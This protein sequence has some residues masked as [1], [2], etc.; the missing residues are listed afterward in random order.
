MSDTNALPGLEALLEPQNARPGDVD[1]S[2]GKVYTA[3]KLFRQH[4]NVFKA[5]ARLLFRESLS[6]RSVAATLML[7]V[8]T[9]RAIRDM[10]VQGRVGSEA[11]AA[12][13]FIKSRA[14]SAKKILQL[15]ALEEIHDRI[16]NDSLNQIDINTLLSVVKAV[17][18]AEPAQ[19]NEKKSGEEF[20]E[21][22]AFDDV[23][24]GLSGEEFPRAA[25]SAAGGADDASRMPGADDP[26]GPE[27]STRSSK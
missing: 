16:E 11:A 20:I 10:V 2:D 27:C 15:R 18:T 23:L 25:D 5:A 14:V 19:P 21:G 4:P 8:N 3:E 13:F 1:M 22:E 6:E 24:N 9:V 12:A 26:T 7:S 17:D